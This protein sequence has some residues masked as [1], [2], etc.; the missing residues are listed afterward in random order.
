MSAVHKPALATSKIVGFVGTVAGL[1]ERAREFVGGSAD[2]LQ[3]LVPT[4]L[5]VISARTNGEVNVTFPNGRRLAA[6]S[7]AE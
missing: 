2:S 7:A 1:I 5:V 3:R 4:T 6:T